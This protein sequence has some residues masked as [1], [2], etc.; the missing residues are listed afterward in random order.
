M[1]AD[2][3]FFLFFLFFGLGLLVMAKKKDITTIIAFLSIL[4]VFLTAPGAMAIN[5]SLCLIVY[6]YV[7][8]FKA[9][10]NH[11]VYFSIGIALSLSSLVL[12][13]GLHISQPILKLGIIFS[14]LRILSFYLLSTTQSIKLTMVEFLSY[15]FFFPLYSAGPI[16]QVQIVK[17]FKNWNF[18]LENIF[19]GL[20][21]VLLGVFKISFI[22]NEALQ[23]LIHQSF[24]QMNVSPS[25]Y[26]GFDTFLFIMLK[27]MYAYLNFSAYSDMAIGSSKILNIHVLE[28]FNFPILA[29]NLQDFWRRWHISLGNWVMQFL[30]FPLI[31]NFSFTGAMQFSL[32]LSFILLGLWHEFSMN[33]LLWGFFHGVGMA[34]VQ[35][36]RHFGKNKKLYNQLSQNFLYKALCWTITMF[37]VAWVQTFA[38][39]PSLKLAWSMTKNLGF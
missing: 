32:I 33:Y 38:N 31:R 2:L 10:M 29:T 5:L 8:Y 3:M 21:R 34:V 6:C 27:F 4:F 24:P 17:K 35:S 12:C 13:H 26:S 28:N 25:L 1:I 11:P 23:G 36:I 37:F 39:M 15:V 19:S 18:D 9:Q 30:F 20:T 22:C 14:T 16:E 7:I